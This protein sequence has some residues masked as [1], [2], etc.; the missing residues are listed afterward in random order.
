LVDGA[1]A[2]QFVHFSDHLPV[3]VHGLEGAL[4]Q[5]ASLE[6]VVDVVG[7]NCL[8]VHVPLD[9]KHELSPGH[10]ICDLQSFVQ[11]ILLLIHKIETKHKCFLFQ[12]FISLKLKI[13]NMSVL[14]F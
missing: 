8:A 14:N 4:H 10:A 1:L 5:L 9:F 11:L 7:E 6:E 2:W 13:C 12:M 3:C